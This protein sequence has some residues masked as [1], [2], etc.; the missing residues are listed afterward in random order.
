[1]HWFGEYVLL[2][3]GFVLFFIVAWIEKRLLKDRSRILKYV[4]SKIVEWIYCTFFF[5]LMLRNVV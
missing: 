1:M 4:Q 3:V 5:K 2:K